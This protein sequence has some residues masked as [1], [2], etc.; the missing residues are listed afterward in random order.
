MAIAPLDF[1]HKYFGVVEYSVKSDRTRQGSALQSQC[2]GPAVRCGE[3]T[4]AVACTV[5]S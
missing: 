1:L 3:S 4:G 5:Y 2:V